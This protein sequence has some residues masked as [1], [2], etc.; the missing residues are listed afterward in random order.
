MSDLITNKPLTPMQLIICKFKKDMKK[1]FKKNLADLNNM[2][3]VLIKANAEKIEIH[4]LELKIAIH[5]PIILVHILKKCP[6]VIKILPKQVKNYFNEKFVNMG[7]FDLMLEKNC[8]YVILCMIKC[9]ECHKFLKEYK[10]SR[11]Q[12]ALH[13]AAK[14]FEPSIVKQLM[15]PRYVNY[16]NKI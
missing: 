11:G 4:N 6:E 5:L 3:K 1:G 9:S 16:N 15:C 13:S 14:Y 2:A 12:T 7:F 8:S 10:D